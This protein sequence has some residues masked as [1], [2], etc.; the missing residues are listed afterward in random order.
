MAY[1]QATKELAGDEW[2]LGKLTGLSTE[3][4]WTWAN[5]DTTGYG[6]HPFLALYKCVEFERELWF[7]LGKCMWRKHRSV[8]QDH[9]EYIR[10]DIANTLKVKILCYTKR[11]IEMHELAKYLPTTWMKGGSAEADKWTVYNK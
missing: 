8:Y 11:V 7:E 5:T 3:A 9:T 10:N 2:N 6:G 1:K 4:F